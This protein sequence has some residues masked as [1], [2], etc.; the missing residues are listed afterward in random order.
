MTWT[1]DSG[2]RT[3]DSGQR[4]VVNKVTASN[5]LLLY[6]LRQ[7]QQTELLLTDGI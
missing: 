2:Q 7:R 6:Q 1:A 3:V 5:L 4:T